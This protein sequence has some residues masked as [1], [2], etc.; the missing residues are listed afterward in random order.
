M[1]IKS[2]QHRD[3][4]YKFLKEK[5]GIFFR[6]AEQRS[7]EGVFYVIYLENQ[8]LQPDK[9]FLCAKESCISVFFNEGKYA[10]CGSEARLKDFFGCMAKYKKD[11]AIGSLENLINY[12]KRSFKL[13]YNYKILPLGIK[14]VVMGVLNV[15]PDSF[16]DGGLYLDPKEAV[17]RAIQM[18]EEGA[19][20]IDIG[21]EST[22][23]G[24][25]RIGLEEEL[26][27]V[28]PVLRQVRKELPKV[29]ISVDTYKSQVAKA[30]LDEGADI[31]NDISG[32][33]FDE[34]MLKVIAEYNC[35]YVLCHTKGRPEEWKEIPIVYEDVVEEIVKFFS[36]RIEVLRSL[37]YTGN[38]ILDPGIG[39]GKLPEHN[40][41]ILKRFSEFKVFGLPLA[42]GVSR[43]S[44]IGLILEGLLRVKREPR[45]RLYGSLGA[46]AYAVVQGAHIVRTHDVRETREFLALLDTVRTYGD[47]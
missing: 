37:G 46:V 14:T 7:S 3:A 34:D 10:L 1:L 18:A 27:R 24:S 11:F 21:G 29:W 8:E 26:N 25:K 4:F 32:G 44:F 40:V 17:K 30:C 28:L 36:E 38:L 15:T 39:F 43:K 19:D 41:E 23:P 5:V 13:Q 42:V 31:I 35:P 12:R 6:E 9:V 20:I 47:F 16:S 22:R 2:F 45:E 33:T